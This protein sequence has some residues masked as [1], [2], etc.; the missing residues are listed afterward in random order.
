MP[1]YK[2]TKQFVEGKVSP[3]AVNGTLPP[4]EYSDTEVRG[5]LLRVLPSGTRQF[6]IRYRI[7]GQKKRHVLGAYGVLTVEQARKLAQQKLAAV[8]AG[9]DPSAAKAE[10]R[11]AWTVAHLI[12]HY[13]AERL[14]TLRAST[15]YDYARYLDRSIAPSIGRKLV[16][17]VAQADVLRMFREA[18]RK[19]RTIDKDGNVVNSGSTT[20]NRVLATTS[21]LFGEA[22]AQGIRTDNPCAG[23]K[24]NAEHK[25]ER[26]LSADESARLLAAC[27]AS[28]HATVAN[29]VRLL[30][31]T[32]ARRG[33]TMRARWEQ[34]DLA[35][36]IWTKP[37]HETKQKRMHAIP[38][39][40]AAVTL[41]QDMDAA[42]RDDLGRPRSPWLFPSHDPKQHI[43]SPKRAIASIFA[44]AGLEGAD[45]V[46]HT[47]RHSF[48]T[49]AIS[50]GASLLLVGKALGHT[51]A[52]TTQ[53]YAH[54]EHDP[55]RQV[56]LGVDAKLREAQ[57]RLR[58]QQAA[59]AAMVETGQSV[60]VVQL[61]SKK[62][63]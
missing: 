13:R 36:G 62:A 15:R 10:L 54:A 55:L 35:A 23:I 20:A 40:P 52:A 1:R 5:F 27:D 45:V 42:N 3:P 19:A 4:D 44:A 7:A 34:F 60:K 51:Q 58:Q 37:S 6:C 57:D 43:V 56:G 59:E 63:G 47:L 50:S 61:R 21:T 29:L 12:E 46:L 33:E 14:S 53:R 49:Q 26:Y 9:H 18:E 38:L 8:M 22:I 48:A 41:L 39:I 28:P 30:V 11:K 24:R 17:D 16:R 2:L 31:F 32:G 25:R